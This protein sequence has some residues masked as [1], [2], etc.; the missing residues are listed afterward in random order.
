MCGLSALTSRNGEGDKETNRIYAQAYEQDPEFFAFYRRMEAYRKG[1]GKGST[2]V[3]SPDSDFLGYLDNQ[4][5]Q[6]GRR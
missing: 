2:Y 4:R 6:G 1:L 3:L 5:G